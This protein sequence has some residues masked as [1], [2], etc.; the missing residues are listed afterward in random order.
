MSEIKI[1]L[2][3]KNSEEETLWN[4]L[5]WMSKSAINSVYLICKFSN[6][7]HAFILRFLEDLGMS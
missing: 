6:L 5:T 3:W 7:A 2:V 1:K 4:P